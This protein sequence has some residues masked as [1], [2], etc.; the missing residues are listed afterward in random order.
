MKNNLKIALRSFKNN[1]FY[2]LLNLSGLVVGMAA[3]FLLLMYLQHET[4][5]DQFH[6]E[7]DRIYQVNL[8]VNFAGDAFNTSN[9]PPPVG[10]T[11]QSEIPEIES[12]TRHFMPGDL[13]VRK[14]DHLYIESN[15]WSVDS[16]FLTFFTFPL[17]EGD[18]KKA[19]LNKN[20]VVLTKTTA[21]KYFGDQSAMG[22]ELLLNEVPHTVTGILADLPEQSSLQFDMLRPIA[23]EGSVNYFSWSWIWLQLDTHV[24]LKQPLD[25][26]AIQAVEAKFPTMVRQHAAKAFKRIGQ[27]LA[28][29][30]KQGNQ[31]ALS[32]KPIKD[33]H[34]FSE[35]QS[36]RVANLGSFTEVKIFGLVALL[37]LVLACINFMN[38]ATARSMKR[39]KE[40][41]VRKVLG[42]RRGDLVRQ[43]MTEAVGYSLIGG[44]LALAVTQL[45]LPVFNNLVGVQLAMVNFFQGW[46]LLALIAIVGLTGLLA[47]SYPALYLSGF[48]PIAALKSK[49]ANRKDGHHQVRNG[50]VV[51]QFAISIALITATFIIIQQI[52]FS[53]AELG[54]TEDN[55]LIIPNMERLGSQLEAFQDELA[56]LPEVLQSTR[57]TD[58]PT[59]GFFGDFYTP[60][61]DGTN[62]QLATDVSLMSYMVDD[63]FIKTMDIELLMGRDFDEQYGTDH[64]AVILNEAAVKY[65]GWENPV[66]QY[67]RY[68]G[69]ENQRFQVVGVIKDFHTHSFRNQIVPFALFH[70]SSKTY[71]VN[72]TFVALRLQQGSEAKVINRAKLLL[73]QFNDGVPF[74]FTFLNEDY[75]ILYQTETRI[76]SI[77]SV[78]TTLSI[79]IACMGLLG[80]IAYTIEQRTKEIGVR[81]ILGASAVGIVGLL[82]KDYLK[83][84]GLAFLLAIPFAYYF[85]NDWLNDFAYRIELEWWMF[86]VAGFAAIAIAFLTIGWHSLRAALSNPV[87]SLRAE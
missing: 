58:L 66:G 6:V 53:K 38:L 48:K 50:L 9:T 80:L 43:F 75:N 62:N 61:T 41:G 22:Q 29:Y 82:A 40:V 27:N 15:I 77:L 78:F 26:K 57:S 49:V 10:E 21:Q 25:E 44:I 24:K 31:W 32:L 5:Y 65:V 14:D 63:N 7:G 1:K 36:S 8:S 55:V 51:F 3:C 87:D 70:E 47:G 76:G 18:A 73:A 86:A 33:V 69:N 85:M 67:I 59:R 35:N 20:T 13:V 16:N 28:E 19:L 79:F 39:A 12:Y 72:Q 2:S 30:F 37:I 54:L 81:K 83:L 56:Q 4:N 23:G 60:E 45:V 68:P 74:N 52:Q 64:Q 11:M 71:D 42:S 46:T 17:L 84:V 34:L